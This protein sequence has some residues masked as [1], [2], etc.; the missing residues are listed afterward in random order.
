[1][2]TEVYSFSVQSARRGLGLSVQLVRCGA[3]DLYFAGAIEVPVAVAKRGIN[4]VF[5]NHGHQVLGNFPTLRGA[6]KA[7]EAFVKRW[8]SSDLPIERCA[9]EPIARRGERLAS[10]L[11]RAR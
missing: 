1:M 7:A 9:C 3:G 4:A 2:C 5:D 10:S 6:K 11:T 8:M